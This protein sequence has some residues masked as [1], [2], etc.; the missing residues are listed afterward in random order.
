MSFSGWAQADSILVPGGSF[1]MGSAKGPKDEQPVM[2]VTVQTFKLD[3]SPVS[4][5]KF[6]RWIE[7]TGY[8]TEADR[9][10]NSAVFD[11]RSGGWSL[12]EKANWQNPLAKTVLKH[13]E[14]IPSP[15]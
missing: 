8:Q 15:R 12:V 7:T 1:M 4:V 11:M 14:I 2:E 5:E 6:G 13:P 9:F 10:G 3:K